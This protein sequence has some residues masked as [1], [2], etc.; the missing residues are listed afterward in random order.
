MFLFLRGGEFLRSLIGTN[1]TL[2]P[3]TDKNSERIKILKKTISCTTIGLDFKYI[4]EVQVTTYNTL[5]LVLLLTLL[6][7]ATGHRTL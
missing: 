6:L 7:T 5:L 4:T 3:N 2:T 1:N